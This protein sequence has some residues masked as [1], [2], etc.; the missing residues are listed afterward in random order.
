MRTHLKWSMRDFPEGSAH[1]PFRLVKENLGVIILQIMGGQ[2]RIR[3]C[4]PMR[5]RHVL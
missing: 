1:K 4:D 2:Y 5:V 3:T